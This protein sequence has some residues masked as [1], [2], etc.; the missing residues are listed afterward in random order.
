MG[1]TGGAAVG[2]EGGVG[3]GGGARGGLARGAGARQAA[4]KKRRTRVE[5]TDLHFALGHVR[6]VSR[7]TLHANGERIPLKRHTKASREALRRRGGLWRVA[8]LS[9]LTHHVA[10]VKLPA[11]RG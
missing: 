1:D 6:G 5:T 11:D 8:D 10:G 7:L 9:K 2:A 3:V 4:P